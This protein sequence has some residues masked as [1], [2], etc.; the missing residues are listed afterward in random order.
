MR[1]ADMGKKRWLCQKRV[2]F[3]ILSLILILSFS[4]VALSQQDVSEYQERL[5]KLAQQIKELKSRIEKEEK[6]ETTILSTLDRIGFKKRLIK[7]EISVYNIQLN[8]ANK[9]L[10]SIKE[11]IPPLKEKLEEEK[12]SI[13]KTLITLYKFGTFSTFQYMLQAED[14][15]SLISES[16]NL[17]VL[18]QHQETIISEYMKTLSDLKSAESD[19]EAKKK[20]ISTLIQNA[21]Q[22]RKEL[23]VQERKNKAFIS[24]IQRNRKTHLKTLEELKERAEQ[25]QILI[26]K[27]LTQ[28]ISLPVALIPLY[29]RKGKLPWPVEGN[30]ITRFGLQKHPRFS[31]VTINNG[32]EIAP[33]KDNMIIR[34]IHPGKVVFTDYFRGYGHL[35]I[36]DHGMKYYSLYGHC[37]DFLV[38]KG[39]FVESGQ[40]VALIGDLSSLKGIALYF[41]IRF[42]TKPLNPLQWL[43]RR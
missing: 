16:K 3:F 21:Q 20:E 11:R 22:K 1:L 8:K 30:I 28:E 41:E 25:L 34:A 15:A 17:S 32:I 5:S 12:Q 23:E 9:E 7:K 36:I 13:E 42:K 27:L 39:D 43:K 33:K 2:H 24:Q 19:L 18:V 10:S 35:I 40:A 29:E 31:T 38:K 37:A 4:T 14:L 26:K 6:K